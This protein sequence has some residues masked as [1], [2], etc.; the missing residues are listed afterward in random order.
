MYVSICFDI[1]LIFFLLI[2]L[3]VYLKIVGDYMVVKMF[4]RILVFVVIFIV[5]EY[6][7]NFEKVEKVCKKSLFMIYSFYVVILFIING[8]LKCNNL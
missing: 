4:L 8:R 1:L 2:F 7:F 6:I 5:I 3:V